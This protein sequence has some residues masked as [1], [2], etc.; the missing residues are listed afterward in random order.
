MN[1][2]HGP[3]DFVLLE[4]AGGHDLGSTATALVELVENGTI[5]LY[6]LV[7]ISKADDDT[8]DFVELENL[9]GDVSFLAG[10]RSGLLGDDDLQAA[11]E[12]ML[13][14]TTALLLMYENTWAIPF[15]SAALDAGGTMIASQRV[16]AE[17]V[18]AVLDEL[19]AAG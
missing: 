18:I 19:D 5:R 17:D 1:D 11:S 15:V 16:P 4:F 2:I 3:I 7:A 13:A 6:D 10:A 12:A 9:G 14:G 8:Y